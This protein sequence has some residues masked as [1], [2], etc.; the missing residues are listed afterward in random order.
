[1]VR[2]NGV[3][4]SGKRCRRHGKEYCVA[5]DKSIICTTCK[6]YKKTNLNCGHS[7]CKSCLAD[8]VFDYQWFNGFSTENKL[9]CPFCDKEMNDKE[10]QEIMDH[11]AVTDRVERKY[12]YG[13]YLNKL[14]VNELWSFVELN[15]EYTLSEREYIRTN[16]YRTRFFFNTDPTITHFINS[17]KTPDIVYFH[18]PN[19]NLNHMLFG[20]SPNFKYVFK[21][22]YQDIRKQNEV[23]F[24]E[25]VEYVF[26][27]KRVERLGGWEYLDNI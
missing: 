21:I 17:D 12:V 10:W 11:L 6:T 1:M 5:H 26:H 25:L 3:S 27:P 19:N 9:L 13:I 16:W 2:C 22:D 24:K 8:D 4:A 20:D 7:F 15:T 18:T 23:L 14:W